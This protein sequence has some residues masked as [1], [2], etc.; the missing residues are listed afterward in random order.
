MTVMPML[1]AWDVRK[2]GRACGGRT[3]YAGRTH[4][5]KGTTMIATDGNLTDR[6][7]RP[8]G[9]V[10]DLV[11]LLA[12]VGLRV[13]MIAHAVLAYCSAAAAWPGWG[14]CSPNPACL[15]P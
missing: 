8:L 4:R 6:L 10:R 2:N 1:S 12:R 7:A 3:V 14:R 15:C 9:T 13:L 11:L 5:R